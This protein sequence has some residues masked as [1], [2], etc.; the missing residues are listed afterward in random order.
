MIAD[1]VCFRFLP[2]LPHRQHRGRCSPAPRA[3]P[4]ARPARTA[5]SLQ[6][7]VACSSSI[8]RSRRAVVTPSALARCSSSVV[9]SITLASF[10][11]ELTSVGTSKTAIQ[12]DSSPSRARSRLFRAGGGA[13]F[14]D[15]PGQRF[16]CRPDFASPRDLSFPPLYGQLVSLLLLALRAHAQK[17]PARSVV[18]VQFSPPL[19]QCR[20][21]PGPSASQDTHATDSAI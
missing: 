18:S 16:H 19:V 20:S 9:S 4:N 13:S 8:R 14:L 3:V 1:C 2:A 21:E 5:S 12:A 17:V 10:S 15:P 11:M 6:H 7:P